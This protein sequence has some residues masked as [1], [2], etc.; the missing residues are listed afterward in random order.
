MDKKFTPIFCDVDGVA[1]VGTQPSTTTGQS[2][3]P[4]LMVVYDAAGNEIAIV[5]ENTNEPIFGDPTA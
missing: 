3:G 1:Q 4:G 2:I 5:D